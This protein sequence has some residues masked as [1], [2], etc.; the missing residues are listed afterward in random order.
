MRILYCGDVVGAAGRQVVLQHVPVL[1]TRLRLDFVVVNGENAAHGF[2]ITARMCDEFYKAGVDVITLGNHAWDK[3]EIITH[4]DNET[5]LL[6]PLNYPAG[7]PG[8]G[9]AVYDVLGGRKVLVVQVMGR[10]FMEA[11]DD[12][13]AILEA[14]LHQYPLGRKVQA[15]IVD[16]HGEAT[17]EKMALG[18]FIDGRVS[19]VVGSHTHVPTAD[20]QILPHGTAYQTDAGMCG[21]YNSVIGL[22]K[23]QPLLR[24]TRKMPT[25]HLHPAEGEG[26][27]CGIYVE[28]NEVEGRARLIQPVR[29]GGR[30]QQAFPA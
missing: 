30:L 13:F 14:L 3:R 8:R 12:P 22:V 19:L 23:E 18:H 28:T 20:A 24:F 7:T 15:I 26:T 9:A 10:L 21:D 1:R 11:L 17:S 2:G 16:V 4:I 25:E 27:L 5:R 29:L 6:R